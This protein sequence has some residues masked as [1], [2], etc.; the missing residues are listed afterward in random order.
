MD[1]RVEDDQAA[2]GEL[3][4]EQPVRRFEDG[5]FAAMADPVINET[6]VE[7][8]INDGQVRM[9]MLCLPRDLKELAVGF[10]MGEGVLAGPQALTG[11]EVL[12]GDNR[13]LVRGEF[14]AEALETLSRRWT[15]GSGCGGGGTSQDLDRPAFRPVRGGP[16]VPGETLLRMLR[17]FERSLDLWRLTGGVHACALASVDEVIVS[18]E[19]VGRHNAF[20]KIIGAAALRGISLAD[21]F[22]MT[23]G[24]LSAEIVSKAVSVRVPMLVS[25]CAVTG[26]G[27]QLARRFG[28]TLVGFARGRR[29][30]VYTGYERVADADVAG[31]ST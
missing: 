28:L 17:E 21:K 4:R 24:R 19:D 15:W 25:R 27:V 2:G 6:R 31:A 1:E 7:L 5:R 23:T 22:V 13:V 16:C 14:D 8:D 3:S 29:L 11:V 30:N 20:D 18:T 10:L 26:L 9:A 12:P